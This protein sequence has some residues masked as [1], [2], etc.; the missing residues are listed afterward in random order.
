MQPKLRLA[1]LLAPRP[2]GLA[3]NTRFYGLVVLGLF[4]VA[5]AANAWAGRSPAETRAGKGAGSV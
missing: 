2:L 3:I 1:A 5:D 4:A